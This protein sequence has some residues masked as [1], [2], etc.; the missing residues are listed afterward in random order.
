MKTINIKSYILGLVAMLL[1]F[2]CG[3]PLK[4]EIDEINAARSV[5]KDVTYTLISD[6]YDTADEVCDCAGFG[7]FS[8]EDDFK[9]GIPAVLSDVFLGL[10]KG[11]S[12]VVTFDFYR[13]NFE[14]ISQYTSATKYELSPADYASVS[15]DAGVDGFLNNSSTA[16][17]N[18]PAI[19]ANNIAS[20]S[21][22]DLVA[23]SYEYSEL[24]YADASFVKIVN[25]DF[26]SYVIGTDDLN[27]FQISDTEG[28]QSW[29]LY[30]SSAG[31]QAAR[32]SGFSGGANPN[33]DRLIFPQ[34][35]LT[36]YTSSTFKL[37]HVVN[38]LGD[39]V[40]GTDLAVMVSTDYDGVN[41][42]TA[43]WTNLD[44]NL[45]PVGNSYDRYD[46]QASLSAYDGQQIY[47]SFYY[48]STDSYSPQWRIIEVQVTNGVQVETDRRTDF[49][50][51]SSNAWRAESD[52][53]YALSSMD[54]D[55]MG[56]P[57]VNNQFSSSD[58]PDDYL[59][60][61]LKNKYSF[62]Q[63]EDEISVIYQYNSSSSGL[64][65]R[66]DHYTFTNGEWLEYQ[67]V[68]ETTFG[69]GHDGLVWQPDNTIKYNLGT[70]DYTSIADAYASIN[71]DGSASMAQYGN[72]DI[73]LWSSDQI[74]ESVTTRLVEIFPTV[75]DQ[76]Y[77]VTYATWEPGSG[78]GSI[79]VIWDGTAYVLVE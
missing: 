42:A 54:Y 26:Q 77:L 33:T 13:G 65:T 58:G 53:V 3:D 5:V 55:A 27:A 35:D 36:G 21:E 69:F 60:I 2:S 78:T 23:V 63:E 14:G 40:L 1:M 34:I 57:G 19:L 31:Y 56:S 15:A 25:E 10:G 4:D 50:K 47:I 44:L 64:G 41:A 48:K 49:Y 45:W 72:F 11:S 22:D 74:F 51:Y 73:S 38:F 61:F 52:G 43:T 68:I 28:E 12:A 30:S 39:G 24:E 71:S 18:I 70:D 59:S 67:S 37:N 75:V 16:S 79:H 32:M 76:K 46:S 9:L 29:V 8:S 20:P 6:D 62:A 17:S 7:N 66:G